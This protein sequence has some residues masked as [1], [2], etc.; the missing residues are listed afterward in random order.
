MVA[1]KIEAEHTQHEQLSVPS[2]EGA[3]NESCFPVEGSIME[4][5]QLGS[6]P[7]CEKHEAQE[8]CS[9]FD[10]QYTDGW[11]SRGNILFLTAN[12]RGV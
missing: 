3:C 6:A 2:Q 1:A 11:R 10:I 12:L 8:C 5:E 4:R 9:L 7:F